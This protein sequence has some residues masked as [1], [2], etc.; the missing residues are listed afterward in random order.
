MTFGCSSFVCGGSD[1]WSV[2][3]EAFSLLVGCVMSGTELG[4]E[5]GGE[6]TYILG[7]PCVLP[8][9]ISLHGRTPGHRCH[10]TSTLVTL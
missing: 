3:R 7:V 6:D 5:G 4:P 10:S 9:N 8:Y 2:W 1:R